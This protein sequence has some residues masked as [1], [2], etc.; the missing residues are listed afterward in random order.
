MQIKSL[1]GCD[2]NCRWRITGVNFSESLPRPG[3]LNVPRPVFG[4]TMPKSKTASFVNLSVVRPSGSP[5]TL[6]FD[7]PSQQKYGCQPGETGS[8]LSPLLQISRSTCNP[9]GRTVQ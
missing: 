8:G 4:A 2:Q 7:F 1:P 5:L 9:R 6:A 3:T